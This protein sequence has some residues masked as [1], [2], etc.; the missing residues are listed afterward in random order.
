[1][2]ENL[3]PTRYIPALNNVLHVGLVLF[4]AGL[5]IFG[6]TRV[7]DSIKKS[8]HTN[9]IVH[10]MLI[11]GNEK[12]VLLK[13][14]NEKFTMLTVEEKVRLSETIHAV[15]TVR[16]VPLNL[17]LAVGENESQFNPK[18]ISSANAKGW[19]QILPSTARP[20]IRAERMNYREDILFD[21]VIAAVIGINILADLHEGHIEAGKAKPEDWTFALHSYCWGPEATKQLYGKTDQRVNVPNLHYPN[22]I[23][24]LRKKYQE[25]GL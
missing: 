16:N 22:K 21:P 8:E 6:Y 13:V 20:Y 17:V 12:T 19:M 11:K 5:A 10:E 23:N 14:V 1:M 2:S 7:M 18:A 4:I 25:L 3:K 9:K 15:A 24:D